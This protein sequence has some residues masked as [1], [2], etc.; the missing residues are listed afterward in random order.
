MRYTGTK[1]K[2]L[3]FESCTIAQGNAGKDLER[4]NQREKGMRAFQ[5]MSEG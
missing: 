5:F 3:T 4:R 1:Q 2:D